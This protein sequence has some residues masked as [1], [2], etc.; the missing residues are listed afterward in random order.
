MLSQA[1][2]LL[3]CLSKPARGRCVAEPGVLVA[4]GLCDEPGRCPIQVEVVA[5][6]RVVSCS[7]ES[8]AIRGRNQC[9]KKCLGMTFG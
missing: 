8:E 6:G 1:E 5:I 4:F 2:L 3:L 7:N 9:A